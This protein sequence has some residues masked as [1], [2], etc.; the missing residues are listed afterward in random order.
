MRRFA[1]TALALAAASFLPAFFIQAAFAGSLTADKPAWRGDR[2]KQPTVT[3]QPDLRPDVRR[4]FNDPAKDPELARKKLVGLLRRRIKYVFV[5]FNENHSFDNEYGTFPGVNGLYSNAFKPRSAE[6]TPGFTQTYTDVNGLTV[7]VRPFRI[8]PKENAGVYDSVDHSHTGLAA[9]IDVDP[10]TG[11]AKMDRFAYDEYQRFAK[12][13]GTGN[14]AKGTQFAR[15]VMSHIDCDTIPFFWQ[16]A[17]RFTIFDNIFATEDTP[18]TPNAVA[19]IAGQGRWT[20]LN[21]DICRAVAAA[22]LGSPERIEYHAYETPKEF[23]A[24]RNGQD[25]IYFLTGSEIAE[26]KLAGKVSPGPAVFMESDVVMAPTTSV[27]AHVGEL[28][29]A[30]ICF[31]IGSA[32]E[33]GLEAYF[34]TLNKNWFR[35]AFSEYGEMNDAYNARSCHAIAGEITTLAS[36]RLDPG[37]NRLSSRILPEPLTVFPVMVATGTDDAQWSAIVEWTMH[38]LVS[39][40]RPETR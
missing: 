28:A 39:A 18:S 29:G 12:Q 30:G 32:A 4:Y 23:D 19:I 15:L 35:R 13:G 14:I 8:G 20:G 34:E 38:T 33:R 17:S 26:Q 37:V 31:M 2:Q 24:V 6:N 9:K 5:I 10:A 22:V 11:V 7:T 36:A 1:K 25:D 27:A 16:W 40:E 3:A 21:V